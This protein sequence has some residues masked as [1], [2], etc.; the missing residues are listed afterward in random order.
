M[1]CI[2]L[3]NATRTNEEENRIADLHIYCGISGCPEGVI[4]KKKIAVNDSTLVLHKKIHDCIEM[5]ER[6]IE[7]KRNGCKNM[8]EN[9]TDSTTCFKEQIRNGNHEYE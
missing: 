1:S 6:C 5:L 2:Y 7:L 8:N 4:Q 9:K 3:I